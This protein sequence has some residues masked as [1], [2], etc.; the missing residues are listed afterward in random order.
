MPRR[1]WNE[2]RPNAYRE[3]CKS[4]R[5]GSIL[6]FFQK[7]FSLRCWNGLDRLQISHDTFRSWKTPGSPTTLRPHLRS[8]PLPIASAIANGYPPKS[9]HQ[10]AG[11]EHGTSPSMTR[12]VLPTR[13][14]FPIMDWLLPCAMIFRLERAK[15]I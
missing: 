3:N 9:R 4:L 1:C 2:H 15:S 6:A 14:F 7:T 12:T 8:T 13:T 10:F 5:L 11:S